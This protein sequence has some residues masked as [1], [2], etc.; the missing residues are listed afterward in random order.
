VVLALGALWLGILVHPGMRALM[1][2]SVL[3][4]VPG[5]VLKCF[6]AAGVAYTWFRWRLQN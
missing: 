2:I 5:D 3:P 1:T 4:F 6:A